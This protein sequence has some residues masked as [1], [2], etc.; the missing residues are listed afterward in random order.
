M[1]VMPGRQGQAETEKRTATFSGDVWADPVLPGV[2]GVTIGTIFF[3]PCARTFWHHHE[4]GQ[5]LLVTAG[6]GVVC[7]FGEAPQRV[8]A[9]DVIW[10][11]PG[12]QHWHGATPASSMSHI[13]IS[14]GATVWA[15]ELPEA[16]YLASLQSG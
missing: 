5:I 4:R 2:D 9:G 10:V 11:P 1:I 7:P 12:E 6:E 16:E 14:L 8:R 15:E 3:A 13:A